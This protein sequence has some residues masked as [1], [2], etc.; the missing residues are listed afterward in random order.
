MK[1][2]NNKRNIIIIGCI[3]I[4]I[5]ILLIVILLLK[6]QKSVTYEYYINTNKSDIQGK[7]L[8]SWNCT[9]NAKIEYDEASSSYL[10]KNVTKNSECKLYF[11]ENIYDQIN[12]LAS[13]S[14]DDVIE[15]NKITKNLSGEA[16]YY[17]SDANN[18]VY[19][20]CDD[21]S[22]QNSDTCDVWRIIKT[23]NINNETPVVKLIKASKLAVTDKTNNTILDKFSWYYTKDVD[24][25]ELTFLESGIYGILNQ[26]YLNS[27]SNYEY[28]DNNTNVH[29]LDFSNTGIKN[30]TTRK[31]ISKVNFH[32]TSDSDFTMK[33]SDWVRNESSGLSTELEIGLPTI[34]DY[35]T[36]VG[37]C[38]NINVSKFAD[39]TDSSFINISDNMWTM[40]VAA[41]NKKTVYRVS[42]YKTI[43]PVYPSLEYEV[44][45]TLFIN[46]D[47]KIIG[48]NGSIDTPYLLAEN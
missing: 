32:V 27:E 7:N 20:N 15:S 40:N 31:M 33:A 23:E 6:S 13:S 22:N 30:K 35:I 12:Y 41:A 19:F 1:K 47:A 38:D 37:T 8:A 44:Y 28:V 34:S 16:L 3:A 42:N 17:S 29:T 26:G 24:I 14:F 25:D 5:V 48:G 10:A 43:S 4:L 18:Y 39:C 21:Y 46:G 9:N 11:E 45:P 2:Q 36:S